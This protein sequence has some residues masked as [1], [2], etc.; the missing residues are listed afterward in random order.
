MTRSTELTHDRLMECWFCLDDFMKTIS[1]S[2]SVIRPAQEIVGKVAG[3]L[4]MEERLQAE[5]MH[6]EDVALEAAD[7]VQNLKEHDRRA[8]SER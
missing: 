5:Q 3:E 7:M 4:Y 2:S 8:E 1:G 6:R